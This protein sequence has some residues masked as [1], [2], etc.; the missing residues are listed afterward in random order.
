MSFTNLNPAQREAVEYTAGPL[1]IVAGAGTGKTTVITSKIC[2]LLE[3]KLAQP[4]EILAL[5]FTDKAAAEM[6]ER[7]DRLINTGYTA[8]TIST[9]HAFGQN[10]LERHALDIGLSNQFQLLTETAAWILLHK[11]LTKL[12]LDYYRPLGHPTRH[13]RELLKHFSKCKDELISPREYLEYAEASTKNQGD[14]NVE[15]RNRLT[16]IA[17]AYHIYNQLLLDNARL[18]FGDLIY[19]AVKLFTERPAILQ[20]W[21][22]QFKYILVD[23]FQDV[24]WA[25][26]RLVQLLTGAAPAPAPQL[27][28]VGDDDQSIYAFRGASVSNILHFKNDYPSAKEI[29]LNENYRSCQPILDAAYTLIQNNNPDRLEIKLGITK[30]LKSAAR[31]P[32]TRGVCLTHLAAPTL[33]AETELVIKEII[34]LKEADPEAA[35]DDFAIL[36]RANNHA[37]PFINALE[38]RR[39][40]YEYLAAGGLYRQPVM[41]DA[42]N[43]FRLLDNYHESP[44]VFRLLCLPFLAFPEP[45]L[46]KLTLFAKKKSISYYEALQ[47]APE[48]NLS[49]AGQNTGARLM[50]IIQA[51]A[52]RQRQ[53]K[54]SVILYNFLATIGYLS[55]LTHEEG[56]GNREAIRQIYYLKEFFDELAEWETLNPGARVAD[57]LESFN[58]VLTA[59]DRGGGWQPAET[60]DS[61]N[62][63]TVHAAKGLEFKYVF[64]VNLVEDRFPTRYRGDGIEIPLALIKEQLPEGDSHQEEERRLFYVAITRAKERVYFTSAGNYGGIRAKKISRFLAELGYSSGV[65]PPVIQKSSLPP[66]PP[67]TVAVTPPGEFIFTLPRVFSFSQLR[68][69]ATCPYQY[70]LAHILNLPVKGNA[71]FSFGQTIHNTLFAFYKK[72]QALNNV[73]QTSLFNYPAHLLPASQPETT[74]GPKAPSLEELL[75]LYEQS[76]IPDWYDSPY[77]REEY[78]KKGKA[79]LKIFYVASAGHW[80]VPAYL[81]SWFKIRVGEYLIQGRIDRIDRQPDGTLE[82]I[83][84]KTGT[85]KAT[86]DAADKEQLL[87]YQLAVAQLPEYQPLGRP[88]KLTFYY[89]DDNQRTSFLGDAVELQELQDKLINTIN[90]IQAKDFTATPGKFVCERCPFRDICEFRV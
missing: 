47:R 49:P 62:I 70:K 46:Q 39:I 5:T 76:W 79:I 55:Y 52:S 48:L 75:A 57:W 38:A 53:E 25:Q 90:R 74:P 54:P 26:Y 23:E 14:M 12:K 85:P 11:N 16:E 34:K 66:P 4:E 10:I 64:I 35:W 8:L 22:Q 82:I 40:P 58:L 1:L 50:A 18:D 36:V 44:A 20:T 69:Y 6:Q 43:Y 29:V 9:F 71:S 65:T 13:L 60:P 80:I 68:S 31:H 72:I 17:N 77:Q 7:V 3:R 37:D 51:G 59:G 61:V 33:A 27:T 30:Q 81:E 73:Q 45:D 2:Y 42:L 56:E 67:T 83:D 84:Y 63:L 32:A 15:E 87:I 19:Y 41:I 24:N 88:G 86:L 89:L 28:V 78:Y 21:Q